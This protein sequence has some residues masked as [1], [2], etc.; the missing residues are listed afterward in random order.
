MNLPQK[1]VFLSYA[2]QDADAARRL[3]DALRAAGVEVWF[4]QSEL[5]GGDAWDAS[6][7]KQ[8]KECALF[9]PIVS[10]STQAR[11][12]G[13][14]RREWN[15]AV[16]R[17][18]DM[19]DD[20]AFLMPVVID[21]TGERE[22]KVPERFRER[23]WSRITD[24]EGATAFAH[25][26]RQV[27]GGQPDPAPRTP[28]AAQAVAQSAGKPDE[29]PSIA[30][31]AFA[32]RSA[33]ADDEYFSDGLADELLTL[34]AKLRGLR[35]AARTSAFSF[36]GKS[37]TVGEIGRALGVATVLE[38]SVR[39]SGNRVRVSVQLV[40]VADG[41]QLWSETYDRTLDDIFGVQEDIAQSVV[42]ELRE[43]L[44]SGGEAAAMEGK[45]R[46]ALAAAAEARS[47]S[48]EA[49]RLLLQAR[50]LFY[51][52]G[53]DDLVQAIAYLRQA[54]AIDPQFGQAWALLSRALAHA[55]AFGAAPVVPANEEAL[56]CAKRALEIAPQ[57]AEAYVALCEHHGM[58]SWKFPLARE[59]IGRALELAPADADVV[60]TA[61]MILTITGRFDESLEQNLRAVALDPLNSRCYANLGRNYATTKRYP[62]AEAA[63]RKALE[64]SPD[65]VPYRFLLSVT[66]AAQ[67]RVDEGLAEIAREKADWARL[68][69]GSWIH[70]RKGD[71]AVADRLRDELTR[72]HAD[73]S[74][75]QVAMLHAQ[76]GDADG[77][78]AW[79]ERAYAQRDAGLTGMLHWVF[80]PIHGDPR[81]KPFLTKMGLEG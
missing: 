38:G 3:C 60:S 30:V 45:V 76:R 13:Y 16:Q 4:D 36:K 81:W 56:A 66:I 31:L 10:A 75:Y 14:F 11:E 58:Y 69:G 48:I 6:I 12:E 79:L 5:R 2:S 80:E 33:S 62:E 44:M 68:F 39:K 41:Y 21:A 35:V 52:H 19:A 24:A 42:K 53:G 65:G 29:T 74:A 7:R 77:A 8:V 47:E 20:K 73:D 17:M 37:A 28:A 43:A 18:L 57:L 78:F 46:E 22:A 64:L 71:F 32:N 49:H 50:F 51:R 59:A 34:L 1:A 25:R 27:F 9:V 61:A 55:A 67:G 15:L 63:Y 72:V 26:V 40:K 23:Q 54:L 70:Y